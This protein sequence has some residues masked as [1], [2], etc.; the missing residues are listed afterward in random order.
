MSI[1]QSQTTQHQSGLARLNRI[2]F[3]PHL[4]IRDVGERRQARLFSTLLLALTVLTGVRIVIGF[5]SGSNTDDPSFSLYGILIGLIFAGYFLSRSKYY[6]WGITLAL[7]G[8]STLCFGIILI[9]GDYS[10][11]Q[12]QA[13]SLWIVLSVLFGSM[14]LPWQGSLLWGIANL[15]PMVIIPQVI[16]EI[17]A[18][19]FTSPLSMVIVVTVLVLFP[20]RSRDLQ[21]NDRRKELLETNQ[22]LEELST[23]LEQRVADATRVGHFAYRA[24][25]LPAHQQSGEPPSQNGYLEE[26]D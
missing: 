13:S 3:Q 15:V 14:V 9:R 2:L 24:R 21:E 7:V 17:P 8:L 5:I 26:G 23:N 4:S 11:L 1:S 20:N 22:E 19:G 18:S 25:Q 16:P 12:V 6:V 10:E